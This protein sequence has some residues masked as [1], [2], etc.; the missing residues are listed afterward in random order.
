MAIG[1]NLTKREQ[2][3]L[4]VAILAVVLA[5]LFWHLVYKPKSV[6]LSELEA[7]VEN[8]EGA[9]RR[10]KVQM[11][12]G[13]VED[14]LAQA[15]VH[16]S[17]LLAIR[18]L[19]PNSNEL[20]SLLEGISNSARRAGLDIASVEPLP[21]LYG[22]QFDTYRYKLGVIGDYHAIGQLLSNI[23]SMNRIVATSGLDLAVHV[24]QGEPQKGELQK[25]ELQNGRQQNTALKRSQLIARFQVQTF[26]IKDANPIQPV[27]LIAGARKVDPGESSTMEIR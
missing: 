27:H 24:P 19:I 4:S 5:A 1:E 25:D 15:R 7:R 23:G 13:S 16:E 6:E 10:A 3:A 9:N 14:I 8:L 17:N 18:E 2:G 12:Q 21:V 26:V 20:A 11:T 22:E